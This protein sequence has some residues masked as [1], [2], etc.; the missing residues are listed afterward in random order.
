MSESTEEQLRTTV[1]PTEVQVLLRYAISGAG[2]YLAKYFPDGSWEQI[3]SVIVTLV[4]VGYAIWINRTSKI[5]E[6]ALATAPLETID[7]VAEHPIVKNV[8]VHSEAVATETGPKVVLAHAT[9]ES[10]K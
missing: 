9:Q 2:I 7:R 8:V 4:T 5:A 3:G 10:I 6:R 1:L